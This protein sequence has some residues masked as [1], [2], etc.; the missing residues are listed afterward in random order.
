[1]D[2]LLQGCINGGLCPVLFRTGILLLDPINQALE[3][4]LEVE[5]DVELVSYAI[6]SSTDYPRGGMRLTSKTQLISLLPK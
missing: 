6:S 3:L 4:E 1:M 5:L 2:P